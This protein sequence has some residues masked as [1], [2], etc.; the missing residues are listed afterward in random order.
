MNGNSAENSSSGRE[1]IE[2]FSRSR[3]ARPQ[4]PPET[5]KGIFACASVMIVSPSATKYQS[6]THMVY[7]QDVRVT[8]T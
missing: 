7:L 2:P 8:Y 6:H 4:K 3:D 5:S 1:G